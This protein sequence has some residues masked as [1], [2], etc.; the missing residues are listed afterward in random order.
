M[1]SLR[2]KEAHDKH[3]EHGHIPSIVPPIGG[4]PIKHK[5][6]SDITSDVLVGLILALY[7]APLSRC[8]VGSYSSQSKSTK[9]VSCVITSMHDH[10]VYRGKPLTTM[11]ELIFEQSQASLLPYLLHFSYTSNFCS[12]QSIIHNTMSL[13]DDREGPS[14]SLSDEKDVKPIDDS[15]IG[16]SPSGEIRRVSACVALDPAAERRLV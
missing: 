7:L 9:T 8:I 10:L 2:G 6:P 15:V 1:A 13:R 14:L 5:R 11:I 12:E 16:L 4:R 3:A